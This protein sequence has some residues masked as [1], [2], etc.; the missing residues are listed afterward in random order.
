MLRACC[1]QRLVSAGVAAEAMVAASARKRIGL[2]MDT[3]ST[4]LHGWTQRTA[5]GARVA[6]YAET[7]SLAALRR[8]AA[9]DAQEKGLQSKTSPL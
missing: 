6:R 2:R 9:A 8:G 3:L 4:L 5:K 1:S 7:M